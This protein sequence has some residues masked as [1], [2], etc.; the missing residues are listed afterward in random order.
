MKHLSV[1]FLVSLSI[2]TFSQD[3]KLK[4]ASD[5]WPPFTNTPDNKA[6]AIDLVK[7]ALHRTGIEVE[8]EITH[9][10]DVM[11][12]IKKGDYHGSSALWKNA[13]REEYM[14]F[15]EPYLQNQLVLVGLKGA[16]VSTP[17]LSNLLDKKVGIVGSYAYGPE[18]A[19]ASRVIFVK[20]QSDQENLE[21][22]LKGEVDYILVDD[23]LIQHLI[24]YQQKEVAKHLAIGNIPLF[25]RSLHFAMRKDVPNAGDIIQ[26]FNAEIAKMVTDG[27]YNRILQL[28]WIQADVD[29]DGQLEMVLSGDQAGLKAPTT[30]YHVYFQ[31]STATATNSNRYYIQGQIY[32][33]WKAVP[34]KYKVALVTNENLNQGTLLRF[35][36]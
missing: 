20:G 27:T 5:A 6:V 28:N 30:G 22:L 15:S 10:T 4:L 35:S 34:H 2:S 3:I 13:E 8:N 12:N 14:L 24:N 26:R 31:S 36:F 33:N 21:Q 19:E 1:L 17:K 18:L 25:T 11:E 9:F 32:D 7:E 29:G 23:L 16:N